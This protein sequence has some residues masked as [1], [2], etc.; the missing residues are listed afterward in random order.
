[1]KSYFVILLGAGFTTRSSADIPDP[2]AADYGPTRKLARGLSNLIFGT[3]R[4][5]AVTFRGSIAARANFRQSP[6]T[7][8]SIPAS[9]ITRSLVRR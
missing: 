4:C 9:A 2:P 5:C 3:F 7:R 8:R 6:G 1:M